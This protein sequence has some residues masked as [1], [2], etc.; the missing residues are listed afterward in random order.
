MGLFDG[1]MQSP[2]RISAG[3]MK[4]YVTSLQSTKEEQ[5]LAILLGVTLPNFIAERNILLIGYTKSALNHFAGMCG[6][7]EAW[8]VNSTY[9]ELLKEYFSTRPGMAVEAG[10]ATYADA[11]QTYSIVAGT[12]GV[13]RFLARVTD[14]NVSSESVSMLEQYMLSRGRETILLVRGQLEKL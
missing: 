3:R 9:V 14:G 5:Q 8:L 13:E 7:N 10:L 11:C 12:L 1:F 6:K 2:D 4:V